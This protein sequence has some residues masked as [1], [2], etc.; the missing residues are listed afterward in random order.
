MTSLFKIKG[1]VFAFF[2]NDK[3]NLRPAPNFFQGLGENTCSIQP[4][5]KSKAQCTRPLRQTGQKDCSQIDAPV[6]LQCSSKGLH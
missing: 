4:A 1:E 3:T 5:L 2:S 6:F